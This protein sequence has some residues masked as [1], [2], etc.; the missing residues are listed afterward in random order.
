MPWQAAP[1]DWAAHPL[2]SVD[3]AVNVLPP[4]GMPDVAFHFTDSAADGLLEHTDPWHPVSDTH[5]R[6][7]RR[8]YR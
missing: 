7:A 8:A 5:A 6:T 1:E 4:I 3:L 2:E